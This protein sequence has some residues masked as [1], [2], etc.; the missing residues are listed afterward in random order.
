MNPVVSLPQIAFNLAP[1]PSAMVSRRFEVLEQT[2]GFCDRIM[3]AS[4]FLVELHTLRW[5]GLITSDEQ[6]GL[7]RRLRSVLQS[8]LGAVTADDAT[9][10]VLGGVL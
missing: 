9:V 3:W 5:A 2:E 8:D 1:A 6:V 4:E 10:S 7:F